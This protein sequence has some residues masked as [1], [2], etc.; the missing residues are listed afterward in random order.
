MGAEK[1]A[2]PAQAWTPAAKRILDAASRLFY[3]E[4]I[5]A[6]GVDAIA[7][8]AQVT[9]KTIYDRFGS[10]AALVTTYLRQRDDRWRERLTRALDEVPHHDPRQQL[11]TTF[12]ALGDWMREENPRG[13]GFVNAY[14]ELSDPG[15]PGRQAIIDQKRW[16]LELLTGLASKAGVPQPERVAEQLLILHEGATVT[17]SIRVTEN[18]AAAAKE[19]AASIIDAQLNVAVGTE[20]S[21]PAQSTP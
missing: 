16:L 18:A 1:I 12:D 14:A 11:L 20:H 3:W 21:P 10:K 13:C 9:K 19:L 7:A 8:E 15:H 6:V 17:N 5:R 2:Q 4:G